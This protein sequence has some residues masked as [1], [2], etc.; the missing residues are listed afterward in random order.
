MSSPSLRLYQ[1]NEYIRRV[2]A[3][4]FSES[5]WINCE[6]ASFKESRGHAYLELIEK[7]D[8]DDNIIAQASA[9]IWR[10]QLNSIYKKL[11]EDSLG[12]LAA[13]KDVLIKV[14]VDYN[15]KYG[16]KLIIEDID[17]SFT[18]GKLALKRQ[19]ILEELSKLKLIDKNK[20]IPLPKV[21]QRLAV[22][23]SSTA[24]GWFDFQNHI[25]QN[26]YG[27]TFT[28]DLYP[29]AM[30]GNLVE[31][32]FCSQMKSITRNLKKYDCVIIIRGGGGKVDLSDF[33]NLQIASAIAHCPIPVFTGIGHEIDES[34]A[35]IV[36]NLSHKTPTAVADFIISYN[37]SFENE[38]LQMG[39]AIS[40][41]VRRLVVNQ[42]ERVNYLAQQL[43]WLSVSQVT[44]YKTLLDT[45]HLDMKRM[46]I[47]KFKTLTI[48]L[49]G[50]SNLIEQL[51]PESHLKRGYTITLF[52]NRSLSKSNFP[53]PGDTIS[54]KSIAG[55]LLST[56]NNKES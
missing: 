4:N 23:S 53:K 36:A 16:L 49:D 24:A 19:A 40:E 12:I 10:T 7:S 13:G 48:E 45:L 29:S 27:Y 25:Q 42:N 56:V 37:L 6:I 51:S 38:I 18:I 41:E 33:D 55:S 46:I 21:F 26:K 35:D 14:K 44:R 32:E 39:W 2:I 54:T 20:S 11:G 1:L 5:I 43:N 47:Q 9:V 22:I 8:F 17:L 52:N 3:L 28:L 34:V 15:E 50:M 31:Q 30:Q